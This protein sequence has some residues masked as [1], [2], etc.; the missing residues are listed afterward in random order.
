MTLTELLAA[1]FEFADKIAPDEY[2]AA[3]Q[4]SAKALLKRFPNASKS[5]LSSNANFDARN[6]GAAPVMECNPGDEPLE[7]GRRKSPMAERV[8]VRVTS[9]RRRLLDEDNLCEKYTVDCCRY[10]GLLRGDEPEKTKIEVR[11][12]KAEKGEQEKTVI[13]IFNTIE[14]G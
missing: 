6:T 10:A 8:L 4:L 14:A 12:R 9:V 5:F 13:E 2:F 11:Q 3:G 1:P 7:T